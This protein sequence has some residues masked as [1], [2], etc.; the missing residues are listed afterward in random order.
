MY[1]GDKSKKSI[2]VLAVGNSFSVNAMQYLW[3]IC[4]DSGMEEI[5]LGN[6]YIAG[7]PLQ[8]HA[9]N[10]RENNDAY[11]FYTNTNGVW[12]KRPQTSIFTALKE[13]DWDVITIQ[14]SSGIS[15]V[16]A[17]YDVLDEIVAFL[18]KEAT[19]PHVNIIWHMTWA[20]HADFDKKGFRE[21][22]DRNQIKMYNMIVDVATNYVLKREHFVGLIP[23]G[24]TM[25]NIRTSYFGDN[26]TKDGFHLSPAEGCYAA[27]MTWFAYLTGRDVDGIEWTPEAYPS[28]KE[29]LTVIKEAV[30][31]AICNP[32][33]ITES[34]YK[35]K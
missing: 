3:D 31:N 9:E 26:V 15:G 16:V 32:Y 6:L 30:K 11:E 8:L 35:N 1:K 20:F 13:Q 22:Y 10:I 33:V 25:Q 14:Q 34:K 28:V 21:N 23:A 29:N 5:I 18:K 12:N 27:G 4:N 2:K 24:T 17:T 7:C 19:N